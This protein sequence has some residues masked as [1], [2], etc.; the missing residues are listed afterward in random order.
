ML[1]FQRRY[2]LSQILSGEATEVVVESIH[3]YLTNIGT[4]I[5]KGEVNQDDFIIFKVRATRDV[6]RHCPN[7][8]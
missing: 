7:P 4:S 3:E 5:R 2:I 8:T 1:K 6:S